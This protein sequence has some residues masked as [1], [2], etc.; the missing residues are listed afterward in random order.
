MAGIVFAVIILSLRD[1]Y[2]CALVSKQLLRFYP[3]HCFQGIA[4]CT[5][6]LNHIVDHR[7]GVGQFCSLAHCT[8]EEWLVSLYLVSLLLGFLYSVA[9]LM[10]WLLL[11]L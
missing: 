11:K 10:A 8:L 4:T 1:C 3:I 6:Y 2:N 9:V 5:S 7:R